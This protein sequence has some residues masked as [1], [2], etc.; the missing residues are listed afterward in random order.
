MVA[1][2]AVVLVDA[3]GGVVG[4]GGDDADFVAARG[5]PC[6]HLAGV[7]ADAGQLG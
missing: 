1:A 6:R 5:E 4:R 3:P 2:A 7:F